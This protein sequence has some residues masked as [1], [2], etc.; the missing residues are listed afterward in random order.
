MLTGLSLSPNSTDKHFHFFKKQFSVYNT[1]CYLCP[2]IALSDEIIPFTNLGIPVGIY[3]LKVNNRNIRTRRE[4][5]S[6]LTIT[7]GVVLVSFQI[8]I[9]FRHC[10]SVSIVN[11]ENVIAGWDDS[12][13]TYAKFSNISCPLIRTQ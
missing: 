11:F 7:N 13:S 3:L 1:W 4:V 6:K 9:Y 12:F 2:Q 5:C 8:W 10:S